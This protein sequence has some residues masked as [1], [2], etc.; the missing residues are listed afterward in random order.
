MLIG[1]KGVSKLQAGIEIIC[2]LYFLANKTKDTLK[3]Y[4]LRD[5][6]IDIPKNSGER[7]IINFIKKLRENKIINI[8]GKVNIDPD[9]YEN[10][11]ESE[12]IK[13]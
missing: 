4:I 9:D 5:E 3:V 8:N 1:Y 12:V 11:G 13:K 6:I 10:V 2:L 7:G